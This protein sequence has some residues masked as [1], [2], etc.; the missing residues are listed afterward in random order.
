V[1]DGDLAGNRIVITGGARGIGAALAAEIRARDA[2]AV[3][4]D[5]ADGADLS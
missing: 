1:S 3:T 2:Y 5:L 4:V